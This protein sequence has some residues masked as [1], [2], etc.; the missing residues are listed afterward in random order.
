MAENLL[1]GLAKPL[2]TGYTNMMLDLNINRTTPFFKG[3][4]IITPNHPSVSDPFLVL[5]AFRERVRILIAEEV[6]K[7]KPFGTILRAMG[8]IEVI[9]GR[10]SEA[11]ERAC[12]AL[13]AGES[14]MIFPE[15]KV[16]PPG[17]GFL[18]PRTGAV[19]LALRTGAPIVP[20]GVHLQ[21][22]LLANV[23]T[24][25][26]DKQVNA[27]WYYRGPYNISIGK[28]ITFTGD[29]EDRDLVRRL[30]NDIM[31]R[32]AL[33]ARQSARRMGDMGNIPALPSL[34]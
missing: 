2:V 25:A 3:P 29:A 7:V 19:R 20:V 9:P 32:I 26:G 34:V 24:R 17:G 5:L 8:H 6:F 27:L 12:R 1:V 21:H 16:T 15:G 10:G 14:V 13:D 28:P 31:R 23:L 4:K 30:T 11:I 18:P 33:L 22:D